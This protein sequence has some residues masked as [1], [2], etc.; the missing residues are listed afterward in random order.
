MAATA[1]LMKNYDA[2]TFV[3]EETRVKTGRDPVP[4][5]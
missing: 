2:V 1:S 5:M 3:M 4:D